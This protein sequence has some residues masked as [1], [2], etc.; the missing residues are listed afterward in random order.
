LVCV[1]VP[2]A[3]HRKIPGSQRPTAI[4]KGVES[5]EKMFDNLS[6]LGERTRDLQESMRRVE[7]DNRALAQEN[8]ALWQE[9]Q[10]SE[11]RQNM[12]VHKMHNLVYALY[13]AFRTGL[14][15]E[16]FALDDA[17][18]HQP[19]IEDVTAYP[20]LPAAGNCVVSAGFPRVCVHAG[21]LALW[22]RVV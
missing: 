1:V 17:R 3:I 19:V 7:S 14:P 21:W 9:L 6:E 2:H 4:K 5:I 11:S 16:S 13:E 12:M 22:Y 20:R 15:G 18:R 10:A 8:R